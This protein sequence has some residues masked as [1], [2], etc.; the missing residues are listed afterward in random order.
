[1]P[2]VLADVEHDG[3][4]IFWYVFPREETDLSKGMGGGASTPRFSTGYAALQNRPS[5]LIETHMLKPYKTRVEATA[6]FLRSTLHTVARQCISSSAG[7]PRRGCTP[8]RHARPAPFPL[9]FDLGKDSTMMPFKGIRFRTEQ[10]ETL[11]HQQ[12]RVYR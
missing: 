9:K 6:S 1:M 7:R 10:S 5:I 12:A 11:R 2:P 4:P 8:D 3:H